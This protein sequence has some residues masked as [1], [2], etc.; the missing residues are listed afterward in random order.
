MNSLAFLPSGNLKQHFAT[1]ILYVSSTKRMEEGVKKRESG[2]GNG[3]WDS[4]LISTHNSYTTNKPQYDNL[5]VCKAAIYRFLFF[6]YY[7]LPNTFYL[8]PFSYYLLPTS[9][10]LLPNLIILKP[11]F[12]QLKGIVLITSIKN[13]W[14]FQLSF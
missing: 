2:E 11:S 8:L 1:L 6:S 7:Q 4:K 13:N 9:H 5:F 14:I 12:F 10:S 3:K